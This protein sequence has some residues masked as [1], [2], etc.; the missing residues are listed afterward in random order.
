MNTPRLMSLR[1]AVSLI[2]SEASL[3]LG[4]FDIVRAP[5]ALVFE[6]EVPHELRGRH[7]AFRHGPSY[8]RW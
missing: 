1:E 2:P 8:P 6:L 5:M 7:H 4:G 3:S